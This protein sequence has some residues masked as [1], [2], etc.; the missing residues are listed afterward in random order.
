LHE[1]R[2]RAVAE[3]SRTATTPSERSK[4]VRAINVPTLFTGFK[5]ATHGQALLRQRFDALLHLS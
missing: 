3:K 2:N 4:N 5:S 1:L